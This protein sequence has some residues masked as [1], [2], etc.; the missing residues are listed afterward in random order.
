MKS[1]PF[2]L[3]MACQAEAEGWKLGDE[4]DKR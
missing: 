1:A 4:F 3:M 2:A